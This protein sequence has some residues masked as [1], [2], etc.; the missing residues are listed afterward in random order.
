MQGLSTAPDLWQPELDDVIA[1][2]SGS[3]R[4]VMPHH[5][6]CSPGQPVR[7]DQSRAVHP[8]CQNDKNELPR[9]E[10][11]WRPHS[12]LVAETWSEGS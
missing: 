8:F 2:D 12:W 3:S 5:T 6:P 11:C 7:K 9:Q 1:L 10:Q 4:P